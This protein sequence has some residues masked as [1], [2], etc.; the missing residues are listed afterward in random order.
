LV[1]ERTPQ[2]GYRR[3]HV[4]GGRISGSHRLLGGGDRVRLSRDLESEG[5]AAGLLRPWKHSNA[6]RSELRKPYRTRSPKA[7]AGPL[8]AIA[9]ASLQPVPDQPPQGTSEGEIWAVLLR[10]FA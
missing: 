4:L 2:A 6:R 3:Q 8:R 1:K 5:I 7:L 10:A 9:G